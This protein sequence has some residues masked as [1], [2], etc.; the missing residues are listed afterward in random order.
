MTRAADPVDE[1]VVRGLL[2]DQHPDLA[3]LPLTR[4]NAGWDNQVWRLGSELA[5]RLPRTERAPRLLAQERRWL[6]MLAPRLP[7]PVPQPVRVGA[8]SERF[9]RPWLVATWVPGEPADRTPISRGWEAADALAD[10]LRALHHPAPA[11]APSNPQR[12][13]PLSTLV[14]DAKK[15]FTEAPPANLADDLHA[16][17]ADGIEAPQWTEVP[18]W[19]HGDLH[20]ANVLVA[21]GTLAGVIDFGDMCAGD[22]AVDLSVA[23]LVLP[24][25]AARR[26]L[27]RY[28]KADPA[29]VRR[30]RAWAVW[31]GMGLLSIG[32][33]W[34]HGRPGGQPTWGQA[35]Q[36]ALT[37]IVADR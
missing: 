34:A 20:P 16:I 21:E 2:R 24:D 29:T 9:A 37:R 11:D 6:P 4:I 18:V 27:E 22:P 7:L 30:A 35:G 12:D 26:F 15:P 25:G 32:R 23:W 5:V 10:F 36:A 17:W 8:P 31:R 1:A 14:A 33:A 28:G 13:A 3:D 19:L